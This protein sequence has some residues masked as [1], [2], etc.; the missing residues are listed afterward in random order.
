MRTVITKKQNMNHNQP[1]DFVPGKVITLSTHLEKPSPFYFGYG[2]H[3]SFLSELEKYSFDKIFFF[4]EPHL[5]E[6]YGKELYDQISAKYPC[7]VEFV[8]AGEKCKYFPVLEETCEKLIAKG[9]SKKS[10]LLAFGGGTVGNVVG[11]AAGLIYRGIRFVEI[12]TSMTGQTD[13]TLSNKQAVN[14]GT[15]K[16]HFGLYHAPLFIWAD[17]KYLKTEPPFSRRSGIIEGIKN[18]FISDENFLEYLEQSLNPELDFTDAKL[19]EIAY[20]IILSKLPILQQDPSEKGYAITLEY[21]HTFG[22]GIEWLEKISHGEAVSY[23]MK[24][25]SHLGKELGLISQKDV[26]RHYYVIE[27]KLGFNNPF[28]ETITTEKLMDAMIADNKKTGAALRFVLLE[29]IGQCYNPEGDFLVTVDKELV[30]KVV[31]DFIQQERQ[32]KS[33][34]TYAFAV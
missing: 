15:G 12:P 30:I 1:F 34:K 32:R 4:T 29:G 8:P 20:K 14:G 7:S 21:G 33:A 13:S 10:I 6:S 2:I 9:A 24:I 11:L 19:T 25:A 5:F 23:G 28:P 18:G 3:Q 16:N 31:E 27:K 17:T 26:E 22:H